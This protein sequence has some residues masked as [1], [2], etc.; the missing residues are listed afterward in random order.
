MFLDHKDFVE[1][2]MANS[3]TEVNII[4]SYSSM[5]PEQF[6]YLNENPEENENGE[7]IQQQKAREYSEDDFEFNTKFKFKKKE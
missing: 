3:K 6:Q 5:M 7:P 1:F 2:Y 4:N